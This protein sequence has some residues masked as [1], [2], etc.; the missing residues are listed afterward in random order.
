MSDVSEE[1]SVGLLQQLDNLTSIRDTGRLRHLFMRSKG[2]N[3]LKLLFV[4]ASWGPSQDLTVH[5]S[6]RAPIPLYNSG[7]G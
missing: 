4:D 2:R 1:L 6:T 7:L 3:V 5:K